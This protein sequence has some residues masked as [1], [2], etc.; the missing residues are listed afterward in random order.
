MN[1]KLLFIYIIIFFG[2]VFSEQWKLKGHTCFYK[3]YTRGKKNKHYKIESHFDLNIDQVYNFLTSFNEFP[4]LYDNI[5]SLRIIQQNDS[6]VIHYTIIDIPWPISDRDM[7]TEMNINQ[8]WFFVH[9]PMICIR[10][11]V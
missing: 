9:Q 2:N 4:N 1:N 6:S 10:I 5:M 3:A 7:I 8:I 11:T